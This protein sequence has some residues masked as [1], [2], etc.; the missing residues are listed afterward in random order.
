MILLLAGTLIL[1]MAFQG[2]VKSANH[3]AQDRSEGPD[4]IVVLKQKAAG[5]DPKAQVDLGIAYASGNGIPTDEVEA[6]KW[7]R[8]AAEQE[9]PPGEYALGEMYLTGRGVPVD[10]AQAV[11]WIRLSAG[12]DHPQGQFNLA[13]MYIEG[14]GVAKDDVKAAEW[15]RKA[16]QQGFAPGQ[17]GL[18]VMY[19]HGTGLPR[20]LKEAIKWYR[21]AGDQ[22]YGDAWNNLALLLA[23]TTDV[24]VR[25]PK[26]AIIVALRAVESSP[27]NAAYLDT[28]ATAYYEAGNYDE[29]VQTQ[30]EAVALAPEKPSY[31]QALEK[32]LNTAIGKR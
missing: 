29:A 8:K 24:T 31:K 10:M 2:E 25:N 19:A 12:H 22:G 17:F 6:V 9:Y 27:R 28:L 30:R 5:G 23:T 7:F 4:H 3:L 26:E 16:A 18:G 13:A 32:Y 1:S 14:M 20:N 15:L 11:K 21:K